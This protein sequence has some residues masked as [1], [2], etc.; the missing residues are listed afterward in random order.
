MFTDKR[1]GKLSYF[2]TNFAIFATSQLY[3]QVQFKHRNNLIWKNKHVF[4]FILLL[5]LAEDES[6]YFRLR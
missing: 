3:N 2:A 5:Y 1:N 4:F 6:I